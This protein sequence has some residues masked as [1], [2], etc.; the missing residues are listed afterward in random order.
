[1]T[2]Q[3]GPAAATLFFHGPIDTGGANRYSDRS[4]N[5]RSASLGGD[6]PGIVRPDGM[7]GR[8]LVVLVAVSGA[9]VSVETLPAD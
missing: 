2:R 1:M 4:V 8:M 3:R 5:T 7:R 6:I 9:G